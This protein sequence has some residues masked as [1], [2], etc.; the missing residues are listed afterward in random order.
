MLIILIP[1]LAKIRISAKWKTSK[2]KTER[3]SNAVASNILSLLF[4]W[5]KVKGNT[6]GDNWA[7]IPTTRRKEIY[8]VGLKCNVS[9]FYAM[10]WEK[11]KNYVCTCEL[12]AFAAFKRRTTSPCSFT[13]FSNVSLDV[14]SAIACTMWLRPYKIQVRVQSDGR[15][16]TLWPSKSTNQL[17]DVSSRSYR[18]YGSATEHAITLGSCSILPSEI[19][20]FSSLFSL[21]LAATFIWTQIKYVFYDFPI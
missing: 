8:I 9:K 17:R 7:P 16:I 21:P 11:E 10:R 6:I 14:S 18:L 3:P 12:S 13:R 5:R 15:H 20:L 4:T 1:S 2:A 19:A